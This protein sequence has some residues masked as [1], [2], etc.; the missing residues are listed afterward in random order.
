VPSN[1]D[2]ILNGG[3]WFWSKNAVIPYVGFA[4]KDFQLGLSY[5]VTISKLNQASIK[6]KTFELSLIYRGIKD[7]PFGIPCPW[8]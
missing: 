7:T 8:K 4:Y 5:D 3:V 1:P 2:V 6:P